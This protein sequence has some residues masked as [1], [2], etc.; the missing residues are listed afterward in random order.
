MGKK[1]MLFGPEQEGASKFERALRRSLATFV[2]STAGLVVGTN[3]FSMDVATWELVASAGVGSLINLAYRWSE[4]VLKE[5]A[6][7]DTPGGD[8]KPE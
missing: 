8:V 3:V 2:F 4:G 5:P 6:P 7:T 1:W